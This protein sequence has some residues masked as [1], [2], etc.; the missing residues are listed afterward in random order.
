MELAVSKAFEAPLEAVQKANM[1]T[2]DIGEVASIAKA[3]GKAAKEL[4][5]FIQ[6]PL[7]LAA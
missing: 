7:K 1:L 5:T 4:T 6:N 2:G 3:G